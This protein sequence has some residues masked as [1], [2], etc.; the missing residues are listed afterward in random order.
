MSEEKIW[1]ALRNQLFGATGYTNVKVIYFHRINIF[2]FFQR[3]VCVVP[4]LIAKI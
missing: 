2:L 4:P 3:N 1:C